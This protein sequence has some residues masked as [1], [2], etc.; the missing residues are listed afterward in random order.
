MKLSW[1][2]R[3]DNEDGFWIERSVDGIDFVEVGESVANGTLFIDESVLAGNRYHYRVRAFNAYGASEYSDV[4]SSEIRSEETELEIQDGPESSVIGEMSVL[5]ESVFD[6]GARAFAVSASG[7]GYEQVLDELRFTQTAVEG[8]FKL[9][10][11]VHAF[12]ADGSWARVGLMVRE[13]LGQDAMHESIVLN[14]KGYVERLSRKGTGLKVASTVQA[15]AGD[16]VFLGIERRAGVVFLSYS[17]D[18]EVWK[19]VSGSPSQMDGNVHVGIAIGSERDGRLSAALVEVLES[20]LVA[21][22]QCSTDWP[23]LLGLPIEESVIGEMD[24]VGS[25][26]YDAE[27]GNHVLE[28]SGLGFEQ[29]D[30]ELRFSKVTVDGDVDFSV[31][32]SELELDAGWGRAGIMLRS[33]LEQRAAHLSV[34]VNGYGNFESLVRRSDGTKVVVSKGRAAPSVAFLRISKVGDWVRGYVSADGN[35]WTLL[36]ESEVELGETFDAG[37]VVGSQYDGRLSRSRFEV[38]NE[39]EIDVSPGPE[40]PEQTELSLLGHV[41]RSS[42]VGEISEQGITLFDEATGLYFFSASGAGYESIDDALRYSWVPAI[43]DFSLKVA[44]HDYVADDGWS[45]VGLMVREGLEPDSPHASIVL[46]GNGIFE[47]LVRTALGSKVQVSGRGVAGS[48][49]QLRLDRVGARIKLYVADNGG[50]WR[51]VNDFEFPL[52]TDAMVG[53][54]IGSQRDGDLSSC[55]VELLD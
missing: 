44:L 2:D 48:T 43:G 41:A 40:A 54:A 34:V 49:P 18:G 10:V 30:D 5:G 38:L 24:D 13:T 19:E 47:T 8:D 7:A 11:Q 52:A 55:V 12:E 50:L 6:V 45:R 27:S 26:A 53:L 37:L 28:A 14:G 20:D 15:V 39:E 35:A 46:N 29:L 23:Y 31:K 1:T 9:R 36:V 42:I 3:S 33:S 16:T 32:L 4:V 21:F 17:L 25:Y 51:L 22:S